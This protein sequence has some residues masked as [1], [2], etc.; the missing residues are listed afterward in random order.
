M[1]HKVSFHIVIYNF[2]RTKRPRP[3]LKNGFGEIIL[4]AISPH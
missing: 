2:C 4:L 1:K 3:H